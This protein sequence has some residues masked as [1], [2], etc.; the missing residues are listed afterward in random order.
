MRKRGDEQGVRMATNYARHGDLSGVVSGTA[1]VAVPLGG[2]LV[3]AG[4]WLDLAPL[5]SVLPNLPNM[6]PNTAL[7]LTL[8]GLALALVRKE[9]I[10]R[11]RRRLAG[12]AAARAAV[13][14]LLT[15]VEYPP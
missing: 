8:A 15:L 4:W 6:V 3:L 2:A 5:K 7:A 13:I 9:P 11:L 10:S 1:A 14:G 12:A